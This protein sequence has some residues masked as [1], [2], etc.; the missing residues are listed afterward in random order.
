MTMADLGAGDQASVPDGAVAHIGIGED[1]RTMHM[2]QPSRRVI[3]EPVFA[4]VSEAAPKR[5]APEAPVARE[6]PA[7]ARSAP[8]AAP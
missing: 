2:Q 7:A 3:A 8:V 1:H 4:P 5:P 6:A